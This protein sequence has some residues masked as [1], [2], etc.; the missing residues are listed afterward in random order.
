MHELKDMLEP[1]DTIEQVKSFETSL[2][3]HRLLYSALDIPAIERDRLSLESP[4]PWIV[5]LTARQSS[6]HQ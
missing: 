1:L 6:H 5:A 2:Q 4:G 3:L